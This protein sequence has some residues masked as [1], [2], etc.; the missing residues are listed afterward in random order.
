MA[1]L[2]V[3]DDNAPFRQ[4]LTHALEVAGH[5]VV[6]ADDGDAALRRF[7]GDGPFDV[8]ITDIVMPNREGIGTIL[9]LVG[10]SEVPIIAISGGGRAIDPDDV[11]E[12]ARLLG[13]RATLAKPFPLA[14]LLEAV[15]RLAPAA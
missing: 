12:S 4:M 10:R 15:G 11:L 14:S 13:A 7:A 5:E 6:G 2:L 9:E 8:V 3:V 1:R